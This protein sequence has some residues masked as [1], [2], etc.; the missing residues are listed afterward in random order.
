MPLG[1]LPES[2]QGCSENLYSNGW[3]EKWM[4]VRKWTDHAHPRYAESTGV[5]MN[6]TLPP[7]I[8]RSIEDRVNSSKYPTP[9]DVVTA[10]IMALSQQERMSAFTP[11]KLDKLLSV[12][13]GEIERGEVL[14]GDEVFRELRALGARQGHAG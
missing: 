5:F 2:V 13:D 4:N 9:E 3:Q 14:D 1:N 12:V 11:G 10:G 8:Q 6:L 7:E